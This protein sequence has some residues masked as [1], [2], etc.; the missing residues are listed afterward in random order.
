MEKSNT[1]RAHPDDKDVSDALREQAVIYGRQ[2]LPPGIP[3][4]ALKLDEPPRKIDGY[5]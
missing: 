2:K 3:E 4:S 5:K 1:D